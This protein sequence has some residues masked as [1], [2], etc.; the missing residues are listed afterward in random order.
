MADEQVGWNIAG[1]AAVA[2]EQLLDSLRLL[3]WRFDFGNGVDHGDKSSVVGNELSER[4]SLFRGRHVSP[5][6]VLMRPGGCHELDK[7]TTVR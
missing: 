1:L 4:A 7:N 3:D 2:A 6:I 5:A